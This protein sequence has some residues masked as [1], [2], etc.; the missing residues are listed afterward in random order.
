MPQRV[1]AVFD[2]RLESAGGDF[3]HLYLTAR[4]ST[5]QD[6]IV[7]KNVKSFKAKEKI[8]KMSIFC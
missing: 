4:A 6:A 2:F 3:F 8:G 5:N 7:Q 1:G